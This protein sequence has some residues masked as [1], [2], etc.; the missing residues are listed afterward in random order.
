MRWCLLGVWCIGWCWWLC[1]VLSSLSS[2]WRSLTVQAKSA[3]H[4]PAEARQCI[5]SKLLPR[6]PYIYCKCKCIY[7]KLQLQNQAAVCPIFNQC[8][9]TLAVCNFLQMISC[10][11]APAHLKSIYPFIVSR[12]KITMFLFTMCAI[13]PRFPFGVLK[14]HFMFALCN[15]NTM[16]CSP[17]TCAFVLSLLLVCQSCSEQLRP[18]YVIPCNLTLDS[19]AVSVF[20][21]ILVDVDKNWDEQACLTWLCKTP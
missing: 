2:G 16:C 1:L 11:F 21:V 9:S 7:S 18:D 15:K 20:V 19:F 14:I 17:T 12:C 10:H 3:A 8:S 5:Y 6:V 4:P 13:L